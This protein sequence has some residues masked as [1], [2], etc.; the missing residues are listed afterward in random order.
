MN[1]KSEVVKST[2]SFLP[3]RLLPVETFIHLQNY[4][5]AKVDSVRGELD[6]P[7]SIYGIHRLK[8]LMDEK[9]LFTE[10]R[11]RRSRSGGYKQTLED[12]R[13]SLARRNKRIKRSRVEDD[14]DDE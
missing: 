2:D 12:R 13:K 4:Y 14:D 5:E 7:P 9:E 1:I 11:W 10:S 6:I 3:T 8:F